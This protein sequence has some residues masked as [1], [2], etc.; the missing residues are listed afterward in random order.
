MIE[1]VI[2]RPGAL[3]STATIELTDTMAASLASELAWLSEVGR[4]YQQ[5]IPNVDVLTQL[6]KKLEL[7]AGLTPAALEGVPE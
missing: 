6:Q 2:R 3:L 5:P 1:I 4:Y 7:M